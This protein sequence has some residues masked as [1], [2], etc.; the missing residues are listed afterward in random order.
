MR[1]RS[2]ALVSFVL[3]TLFGLGTRAGAEDFTQSW[4]LS[5]GQANMEIGNY[6]AA[7]EAYEKVV[8][9]EPPGSHAQS[10]PRL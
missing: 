7:I 6:K 10:R 1:L 3:L 5:R 2:L 4:Y 8:E 9:P